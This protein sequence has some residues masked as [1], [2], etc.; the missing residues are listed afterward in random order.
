M[1]QIKCVKF[2]LKQMN[3]NKTL[4]IICLVHSVCHLITI[5]AS[6]ASTMHAMFPLF[7]SITIHDGIGEREA[8][9]CAVSLLFFFAF[10]STIFV[11]SLNEYQLT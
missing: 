3:F 7:E 1:A 8:P 5:A 9:N 6:F 4:I 10:L 2:Q 11:C